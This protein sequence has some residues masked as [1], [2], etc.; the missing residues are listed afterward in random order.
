MKNWKAVE[1]GLFILTL[2][3]PICLIGVALVRSV[4]NSPIPVEG[5]KWWNFRYMWYVAF[6][7]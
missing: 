1:W 7:K 5:Y 2:T 6:S 3:I 4:T